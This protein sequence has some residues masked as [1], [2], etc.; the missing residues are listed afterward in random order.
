VSEYPNT[1]IFLAQLDRDAPVF[2]PHVIAVA[3]DHSQQFYPLAERLITYAKPTLGASWCMRLI[4]GYVHFVMDVNRAQANYEKTGHY[5]ASRYVDIKR[6]VYDDT[7]YMQ[8]YHWGMFSTLFCWAHHLELTMFYQQHFLAP[9]AENPPT[10][11]IDLGCGSGVWSLLALDMWPSTHALMVDITPT[12]VQQTRAML[13]TSA[14]ANRATVFEGD[15]L[16]FSPERAGESVAIV[17]A[18]LA[19]HLENP[20]QYFHH[21]KSLLTAQEKAF[22]VVALTAAES[23]HI[24]EFVHELDV[25]QM[26]EHAGLHLVASRMTS[27]ATRAGA[28]FTPRSF[29][30]IVSA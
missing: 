26:I 7:E 12:T 13:A 29:G 9:L 2:S 11:V 1:D 5:A 23:D 22:I 14:Y 16:C 27:P 10:H 17:S 21:I 8:Q 6:D 3:R 15:A 25:L 4:E 30:L 28:R 19:A 20:Q 24:Y 18:F